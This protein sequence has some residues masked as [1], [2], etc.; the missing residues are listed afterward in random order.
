MKK[1]HKSYLIVGN[2]NLAKHFIHYLNLLNIPHHHWFRDSNKSFSELLG[3]SDKIVVLI[4]DDSIKK[5]ILNYRNANDPKIWI[6]CSGALFTKFAYGVHPLSTF[7]DNLYS[8][9]TYETI[10][11]ILEENRMEFS[12]LFP[13]LPNPSYKLPI[14]FKTFYHAWCSIAGNFTTI[15]WSEFFTNLERIGIPRSNAHTYLKQISDNLI[16][17]NNPLTGPIVRG[18]KKIIQKHLSSLDGEPIKKIYEV[19]VN[20]F[21]NLEIGK[22]RN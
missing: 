2:G 12:D 8:L 14:E 19:F 13:E 22:N 10:P 11:F 3:L 4:N 1:E 20:S 5:F 16:N 9:E 6:H 7:S 17:T 18:D 21:S 15:L